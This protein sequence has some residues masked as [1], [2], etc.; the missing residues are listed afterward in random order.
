[1]ACQRLEIL[2]DALH[3]IRRDLADHLVG[4]GID[5][6]D[7]ESLRLGVDG[8][9]RIRR[10]EGCIPRRLFRAWRQARSIF[11]LSRPI[12]QARR[13]REWPRRRSCLRTDSIRTR[14]IGPV[15]R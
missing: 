8:K 9:L 4:D 5:D 13:S 3:I 15:R 2:G 12:G 1:M 14:S 7:A 11:R 6:L 10:R